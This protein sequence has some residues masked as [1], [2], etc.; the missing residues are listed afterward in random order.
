MKKSYFILSV[1]TLVMLF[2]IGNNAYA[3]TVNMDK[4]SV[5]IPNGF[6]QWYND[7]EG[8]SANISYDGE[9]LGEYVALDFYYYDEDND[10]TFNN[11]YEK[12]YDNEDLEDIV[13]E[14]EERDYSNENV[15]K[16]Y[17]V[18]SKALVKIS[19][20][21]AIKVRYKVVS[22]WKDLD[23][24][25]YYYD[26]Y[27]ARTD[28]VSYRFYAAS[29]NSKYFDTEEWKNCIKSIVIKDTVAETRVTPFTDV[30]TKSWYYN[31]VKYCYTNNIINGT[32]DYTFAPNTKLTRGMLVAILYKMEGSPKVTGTNKFSDVKSGKYYYNAVVWASNNGIVSGYKGT[33]KFG[34][35]D[36]ITRQD[37]AG[38]LSNYC[39]YKGKYV[40]SNY[41]L[42]SFSDSSKVSNYALPAMRWAVKN[43]IINGSN[44]KLNPKG[45]ATRAEAAAMVYNY[46]LNMK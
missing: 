41:A 9:Y 43:N 30:Q 13:K 10:Y 17:S 2:V 39:K 34:P 6:E 29:E 23:D 31:A 33:T 5:T 40:K 45:N 27:Y 15:T 36:N 28:D 7:N 24:D 26:M 25:T 20:V 21:N 11:E 19:G 1:L 16:T 18:I 46:C 22:D 35:N 12:E 38:M 32:N 4:M 42:T 37:L 8:N 44:G 3:A 14:I